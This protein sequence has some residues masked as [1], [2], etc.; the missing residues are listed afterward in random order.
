MLS[1]EL[2]LH[3]QS[4]AQRYER[5]EFIV[6]DPSWY[7]HQVAGDANREAT[8]LLAASLSYGRRE[9]FMAKISRLT[10]WADGDIYHW[11]LSGAFLDRIPQ[12]DECFYRL[13][14]QRDLRA[15]LTGLQRLLRDYGSLRE[16]VRLSASDTLSAVAALTKYFSAASPTPMVPRDCRSACKRICMFMRWMVRSSSPVD[17]GLWADIIDRRTLIMPMDTHVVAE[18]LRLGLTTSRSTTMA[19]AVRL[20]DTLR[21]VFPD[22]PV[23]ADFALF[24]LGVEPQPNKK[25]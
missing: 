24:G 5:P 20:T 10:D 1:A 4:L 3:L 9:Q 15:F 17:L 6:G 25:I 7:M 13:Y 14:K 11:T 23:K 18:A 19:A 16:F 21:E 2:K 12:S 8:A 22:D